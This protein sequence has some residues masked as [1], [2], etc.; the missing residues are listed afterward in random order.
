M[1]F[2]D[3][4]DDWPSRPLTAPVLVAD[5]LDLVVSPL[6]R[7]RGALYLLLCDDADRLLVPVAIDEVESEASSFQRVDLVARVL[8]MA[9]QTAPVGSLLA[10][11]ARPGGLSAT[12][13]D[14]SW[15]EAI[16]VAA[17]GRTRLLGVHV[18][19]PDGS[20]PVPRP[21]SGAP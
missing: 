6:S 7:S 13:D 17:D 3:L 14:E 16:T 11:V 2:D 15:A 18:I 9:A 8:D 12:A 1:S 10:A 21:V 5:V 20:R 4:P 19:T